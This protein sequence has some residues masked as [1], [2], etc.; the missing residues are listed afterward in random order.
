MLADIRIR[1]ETGN[2]YGLRDA[3]RGIVA[4]G[5]NIETAQQLVDVLA[6]GDR[7]V[8]VPVLQQLYS[9]MKATPVDPDLALLWEKLGVEVIGPGVR[10]D[11]RAPWADTRHAIATDQ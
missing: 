1:R 2:Y 4:G 6:A 10:F 11:D 8:G 5:G 9:E 7:A 3:L